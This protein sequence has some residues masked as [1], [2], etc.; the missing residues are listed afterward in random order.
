MGCTQLAI[1]GRPN[2]GKSTLLNALIGEE[3]LV[4]SPVPHTTRD[5]VFVNFAYGSPPR[6]LTLIDT[7]GLIGTSRLTRL[8]MSRVDGLAMDDAFRSI[9]MANV[10]ALTIDIEPDVPSSNIVELLLQ[11]RDRTTTSAKY[12]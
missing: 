5:S 4:T 11:L 9:R 12:A 6:D 1:V 2:T 7:A 3:R 10:C 8:R